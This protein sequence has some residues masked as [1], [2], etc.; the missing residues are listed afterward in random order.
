VAPPWHGPSR[1]SLASAV[2]N[3]VTNTL[4][5]ATTTEAVLGCVSLC[6]ALMGKQLALVLLPPG[7]RQGFLKRGGQKLSPLPQLAQ[8]R[9]EFFVTIA[10]DTPISTHDRP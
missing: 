3:T 8:E 5:A 4:P 7:G 1:P 9:P 2:S 10:G 6:C